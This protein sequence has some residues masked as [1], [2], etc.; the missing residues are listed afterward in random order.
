M[1]GTENDEPRILLVHSGATY[2]YWAYVDKI[3]K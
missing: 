2:R 1:L 3:Q